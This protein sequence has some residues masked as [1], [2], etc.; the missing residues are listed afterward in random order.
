MFEGGKPLNW[1]YCLPMRLSPGQRVTGLELLPVRAAV[2]GQV[3]FIMFYFPS[4]SSPLRPPG[5]QLVDFSELWSQHSNHFL[6]SSTLGAGTL[7]SNLPLPRHYRDHCEVFQHCSTEV[8]FTMKNTTLSLSLCSV[9]RWAVEVAGL[10][11]SGIFPRILTVS[12]SL[13]DNWQPVLSGQ[14]QP[15]LTVPELIN[16]L[17]FISKI[18]MNMFIYILY[19]LYSLTAD[20]RRRNRS[21]F[22]I[23][24]RRYAT[25][26]ITFELWA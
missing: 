11:W 15:F 14:Y 17:N 13:T 20:W 16:N 5:D 23:I 3:W 2:P 24:W 22:L 26:W 7:C 10:A 21:P 18:F 12:S 6:L 25:D 19:L 8:I 9:L 4:L 1:C